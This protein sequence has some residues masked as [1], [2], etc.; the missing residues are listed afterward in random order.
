MVSGIK[1]EKKGEQL[2][3]LYTGEM[4]VDEVW[5]RLSKSSLPKLWVPRKETFYQIDEIPVL[6]TG[7]VNLM[8]V[9]KLAE[10]KVK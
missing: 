6:G 1:D 7:K 4:N 2:V 5:D 3:V 10:E 9:K 8:S